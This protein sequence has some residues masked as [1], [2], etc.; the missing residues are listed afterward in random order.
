MESMTKKQKKRYYMASPAKPGIAVTTITE[1]EE[2]QLTLNY[3]LASIAYRENPKC[4][5]S[6]QIQTDCFCN[7]MRIQQ[8]DGQWIHMKVILTASHWKRN[9]G[10]SASALCNLQLL[11]N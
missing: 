4:F 3:I 11:M 1:K 8:R 7:V 2:L 6:L 10:D 5:I 9:Q